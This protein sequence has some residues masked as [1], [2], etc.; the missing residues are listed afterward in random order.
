MVTGRAALSRPLRAR[1][2][3]QIVICLFL[4]AGAAAWMDRTRPQ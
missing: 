1:V 3:P 4:G 2:T